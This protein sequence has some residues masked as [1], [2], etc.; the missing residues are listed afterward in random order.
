MTCTCHESREVDNAEPEKLGKG[1]LGKRRRKDRLE[2]AVVGPG[3]PRGQLRSLQTRVHPRRGRQSGP[4][5][6]SLLTAVAV[7]TPDCMVSTGRV[8]TGQSGTRC[9]GF[10]HR[11]SCGLWGP[12]SLLSPWRGWGLFFPSLFR[13]FEE[14]GHKSTTLFLHPSSSQ[15]R[16]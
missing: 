4:R 12:Q 10:M 9:Q 16:Q 14:Q 2:L 11:W 8:I 6:A 5:A 3:P 15:S 1:E 7:S 13:M